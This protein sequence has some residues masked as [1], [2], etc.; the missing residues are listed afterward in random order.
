VADDTDEAEDDIENALKAFF[1]RLPRT[2]ENAVL[3]AKVTSQL[4]S[5]DQNMSALSDLIP[6]GAPKRMPRLIMA[7]R[8]VFTVCFCLTKVKALFTTK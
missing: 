6:G 3:Q 5:V 2:R 7:M 1:K 8:G 4:Q